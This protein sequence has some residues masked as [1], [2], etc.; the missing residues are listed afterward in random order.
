MPCCIGVAAIKL[1]PGKWVN[2]D[3]N[4]GKAVFS[5]QQL[6]QHH[7]GKVQSNTKKWFSAHTDWCNSVRYVN[8]DKL[9]I[10]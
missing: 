5:R 2:K 8:N 7:G 6:G 9:Y 10:K 3:A 1:G 4:S